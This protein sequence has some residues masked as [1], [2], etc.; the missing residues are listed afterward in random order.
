[1]AQQCIILQMKRYLT[2][3]LIVTLGVFGDTIGPKEEDANLGRKETDA[4]TL[5]C[6]Y[7]SSSTYIWLY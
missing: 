7:E 1:M 2:I 3:Y 4:V 5:K 6:S